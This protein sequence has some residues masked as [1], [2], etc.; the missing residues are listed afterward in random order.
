MALTDFRL[1]HRLRVRW[2]EVDPQN[3][4]FN[5]NY[6]VYFDVAAGEYWR[7]LGF[8]YPEGMTTLGV[9]T[10]VASAKID[11]HRSARYDDEI[12]VCARTTRL[13]RTSMRLALE[14]HRGDE[15]LVTGELIYVTADPKTQKPIPIPDTLRTAIIQYEKLAPDQ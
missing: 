6:L 3:I 14:I 15:H 1:V 4:V 10:F 11:F 5:P 2:S 13:G 9:D 7:E 12:D 8:T